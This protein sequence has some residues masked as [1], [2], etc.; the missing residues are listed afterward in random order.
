MKSNLFNFCLFVFISFVFT[1]CASIISGSRQSINIRTSNGQ[2]VKSTIMTSEGT[3]N[4]V[5][6]TILNVKR[7][8]Q[9]IN[10]DVKETNE[11][12][13][14]SMGVSS[15]MNGWFWGNIVLGGFLG[16]TTDAISGAMWQYD[17]TVTVP[18]Q[19]KNVQQK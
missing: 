2:E 11:Y 4:T 6:P 5:L 8:K 18:I 16:S 17:D 19:K 3:G 15:R 1:G 12:E 10:I 7:A 14:S 13:Q 9:T